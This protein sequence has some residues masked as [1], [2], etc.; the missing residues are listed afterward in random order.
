MARFFEAHRATLDKALTAV[1]ARTFWS[2]YPEAPS[3]KIYG[4]TAKDDGEAQ[5]KAMLG[6]PFDLGRGAGN[7][8]GQEASPWGLALGISYSGTSIDKLIAASQAAGKAWAKASI[9]DRAG[10]CLEILHRINRQ[11]FLMAN[12]IMH[13]TGQGFAMAFQAGG[14]HAQDRGLEAVAYAYLEMKR[15]PAAARWEKPQGGGQEPLRM[16]K[17]W[18]IVPR[19]IGVVIGCATFP[20]WNTYPGLFASLATGNTVIVK[21]HP[22]AILPL[23]ITV[24]IAREVLAEAGFDPDVV[25]LAPDDPDAPIAKE[26]VTHPAVGIVDFTGSNAF[27]QWVRDN[28]RGKQVYTE[29]AGVNS[30]VIH[31]TPS[32]KGMCNNIA[33]S[34]SLY[35]GQM[36]TAPQNIYVPR[37]GIDSDEGHK[38]LDDVTKGIAGAVEKLVGAPERAARSWA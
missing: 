6:K 14:P 20:T 7:P 2:A 22:M 30:I 9:D 1:A 16:D 23:A 27:G 38:S 24:R 21:P 15:I 13:T 12:A 10:V 32:F 35:S 29:E 25:L 4:E 26:L 19:G 3:G 28:A 37:A 33:F 5:F 8:V 34:L 18:R 36:C 31:S 11:S 17:A